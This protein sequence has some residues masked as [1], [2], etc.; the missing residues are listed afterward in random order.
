M[1]EIT[2]HDFAP[3]AFQEYPKWVDGVLIE[4][5]EEAEAAE[6]AAEP[7]TPATEAKADAAQP[8]T[9]A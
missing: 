5:A 1:P 8:K 4:R 7:E 6:P 2:G 9:G 3:Y